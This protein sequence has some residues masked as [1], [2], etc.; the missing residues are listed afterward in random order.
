MLSTQSEAPRLFD[1]AAPGLTS[2]QA[3]QSLRRTAPGRTVEIKT[4]P[5]AMPWLPLVAEHISFK[6]VVEPGLDPVYSLSG[7][8]PAAATTAIVGVRVNEE[9]AGPGKADLTIDG[10]A[11]RQNGEWLNRVPNPDF[12]LNLKGWALPPIGATLRWPT[13]GCA[14]SGLHF[15]ATSDQSIQLNSSEFHV[16][17]GAPFTATFTSRIAPVSDGSEY[18]AVFFLR[19][20]SSPSER[21]VQRQRIPFTAAP[22]L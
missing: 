15:T 22:T 16:A 12:A 4:S 17:G 13:G 3:G 6:F 5:S 8:V 11:Y 2:A 9:G 18:F 1:T 14:G 10:M 19:P 7:T 21:E 20:G